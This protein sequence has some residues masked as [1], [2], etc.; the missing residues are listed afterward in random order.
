MHARET[1]LVSAS[2]AY[3]RWAPTWDADA[4]ALVA[5]ES[6]YLASMLADLHGARFLDVACGTG[7]WLLHARAQGATVAGVDFCREMLLEAR[8][9]PQIRGKLA[10]A[11]ARLLPV[12]DGWADTVL[13]A[14]ALGH[15]EPLDA[16]IRELARAAR[17]GGSVL[18]SDFHPD[19]AQR[20]WKRTFRRGGEVYEIENHPYT[21]EQLARAARSAGLELE[22]L[23]EPCFGEPEREIFVRAGKHH[24]FDEAR[25][26]PAALIARWKRTR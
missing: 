14:L 19:A 11:D 24:L 2:E 10:L 23:Q 13:M 3:R 22:E 6:R 17:I 12:P 18:V 16:V 21:A 20:G 8:T 25:G 26:I 15:I 5:L 7:R 1:N 9:K 4:T